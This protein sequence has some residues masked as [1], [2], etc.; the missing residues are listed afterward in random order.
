MPD[1]IAFSAHGECLRS[2]CI[3]S[4]EAVDSLLNMLAILKKF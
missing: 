1:T 4:I 3:E 2:K